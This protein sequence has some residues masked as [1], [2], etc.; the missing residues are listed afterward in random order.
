MEIKVNYKML[1]DS[2][3]EDGNKE[4]RKIFSF[5]NC[6]DDIDNIVNDLI[7]GCPSCYLISGYRGAG[8]SSFIKRVES[9]LEEERKKINPENESVFKY[10]L[11][12]HTNFSKYEEQSFLLRK[13]IRGLYLS[14]INEEN[15]EVY[16]IFKNRRS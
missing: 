13:L 5:E 9:V 8:K 10:S 12:I 2:P 15:A 7:Y 4:N 6:Q 11:F 1:T 16:E 14:I 3:Y